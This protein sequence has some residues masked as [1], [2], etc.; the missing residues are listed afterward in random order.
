MKINLRSYGKLSRLLLLLSMFA[1]LLLVGCSDKDNTYNT[2]NNSCCCGG[3]GNNQRYKLYYQF[4][5]EIFAKDVDADA[6]YVSGFAY[7]SNGQ[8]DSNFSLKEQEIAKMDKAKNGDY[9]AELNVSGNVKH[10]DLYF[11]YKDG[12]DKL[13]T[14]CKYIPL[15][16]DT[17]TRDH[18]III[19]CDANDVDFTIKTYDN[20]G[21]ETCNFAPGDKIF[22]K[23][24]LTC[25]DEGCF[26]APIP[27]N[28][29]E[30]TFAITALISDDTSVVAPSDEMDDN[31]LVFDALK[32]GTAGLFVKN[33]DF[34]CIFT[35]HDVNVEKNTPDYTAIYL[36]PEGYTV[37]NDGTKILDPNG[38]EVKAANLPDTQVIA[39]GGT[40]TFVAIGAID[41]GTAAATYTLLGNKAD[42]VLDTDSQNINNDGFKVSVAEGATADDAAAISATYKE[43]TS[44]VINI[45]VEAEDAF[46]AIYLAPE[47]YTVSDDGTKILDPNGRE[48]DVADLPDTQVIAAGESHT[49]VAIGAKDDGTAA[50]TYTLLGDAADAVMETQSQYIGNN[51]FEV[52]VAAEASAADEATIS[53]KYGDLTS[54]VINITVDGYTAIYIAPEGYS[55][56][57]DGTK[58]LD[59]NGREVEPA[60]IPNTQSIAVGESHT[61]VAIGAKDD[62]TGAATYALLGNAAE[63]VLETESQNISNEDFKVTVAAEAAA[64]DEATISAE[65]G[66]LTSNAINITV[67]APSP[68]SALYVVPWGYDPSD[69]G[70]EIRDPYDDPVAPADLPTTHTLEYGKSYPFKVIGAREDDTG[71]TIYEFVTDTVTAEL[72][73]ES[74]KM[75]NENFRVSAARNASEDDT[76]VLKAV[77]GSLKSNAMTIKAVPFR[78]IYVCDGKWVL[79]DDGS[80]LYDPN[81]PEDPDDWDFVGF[82]YDDFLMG[83][84]FGMGAFKG[85]DVSFQLIAVDTVEGKLKRIPVK[86]NPGDDGAEML[87]SGDTDDASL[88]LSASSV[89]INND[90]TSG[91]LVYVDTAY[92]GLES[93]VGSFIITIH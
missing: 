22:A 82:V 36:A 10:V 18:D 30:R 78:A 45:T 34:T 83:V 8:L 53:A 17:T 49:F 85:T 48:I 75:T 38:R 65:Y 84:N 51:G 11:Y 33:F 27:V 68:Y 25:Q 40:H 56:N 13:A 5:Q 32:A 7:D 80:K 55:V 41:D 19:D 26:F 23:V 72:T 77:D 9:L 1:T 57:D 42:A 54:N 73:T 29:S 61:F 71:T 20:T 62:G 90:A 28:G 24:F 47:G 58:I 91:E 59:P 64:T 43:L 89:H 37:S 93:E 4:K 69:D 39:A 66:A 14:N 92:K 15:D 46:T 70:T 44:N 88:N 52:T 74:D 6:V 60:N 12:E 3:G 86:V 31:Y 21:R 35:E 50:P 87:L 76:A 81:Y 67:E 2:W 79:S 16:F 63:A